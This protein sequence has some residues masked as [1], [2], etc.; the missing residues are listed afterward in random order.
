MAQCP[1]CHATF[2]SPLTG[3]LCPKCAAE[4]IAKDVY[5]GSDLRFV[6]FLAGVLTA[7]LA[8]MPGAMVG[9]TIGRAVGEASRGCTIGVV[10]FSLCGLVAGFWIGPWIVMRMES[11]K[12]SQ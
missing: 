6:G 5:S 3:Q 11:A 1:I 8:S 4:V 12:R 9:Y 2:E 7:A 10:L